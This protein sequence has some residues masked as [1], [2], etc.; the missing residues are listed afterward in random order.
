M[1]NVVIK[2]DLNCSGA[3]S[4]PAI[5]EISEVLTEMKK[6][7]RSGKV[8]SLHEYIVHNDDT[9]PYLDIDLNDQNPSDH[10]D[11]IT[12]IAVAIRKYYSISDDEFYIFDRSGFK[13]DKTYKLS[14]RVILRYVYYSH[15]HFIL[16]KDIPVLKTMIAG[17]DEA[18]YSDGRCMGLPYNCKMGDNRVLKLIGD[19][20][21]AEALEMEDFGTMKEFYDGY[22][23]FITSI[24]Y[25]NMKCID[26][27]GFKMYNP[28][29]YKITSEEDEKILQYI[30][31]YLPST[32]IIRYKEAQ[33]HTVV[34]L[35]KTYDECPLC[36]RIH[37]GNRNY[38]LVY[39]DKMV[40]KCHDEK[41]R[42]QELVVPTPEFLAVIARMNGFADVADADE[43]EPEEVVVEDVPIP[44]SVVDD[45][46]DDWSLA[47][48]FAKEYKILTVQH[49]MYHFDGYWKKKAGS[50]HKW[51]AVDFKDKMLSGCNGDQFRQVSKLASRSF[52]EKL[53]K[54][55]ADITESKDIFDENPNLLGFTNGVYDLLTDTF[56]EHKEDDY[57]SRIIP[58]D[59]KE[60]K[61]ADVSSLLEWFD[62]FMP[63]REEREFLLKLLSSTI[64]GKYLQNIVFFSGRGG[65]GK[66]CLVDLMKKTLGPDLM[67]IGSCTSLCSEK[68]GPNPEV[69]NM[70]MKRCV[71]FN[72][73]DQNKLLQASILKTISGSSTINARGLYQKECDTKLQATSIILC[74]EKPRMTE[75]SE[76]VAR[77]IIVVLFRA[78][79]KSRDEIADM[80]EG[81]LYM[82][83]VNT[84]YNSDEFRSKYK[85]AMLHLLLKYFRLF[86]ADGYKLDNV[87]Q[88]IRDAG[89]EYLADSDDFMNWFETKYS[90]SEEKEDFV[91]MKD[92]YQ[93]FQKSDLWENLPKKERRVQTK[94]KVCSS[95]ERN[96]NLR[97]FYR[98]RHTVYINGA[99]KEFNSVLL[100]WT[101]RTTEDL[102]EDE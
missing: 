63:I 4:Q 57:V 10:D 53:L 85:Y 94:K 16:K 84:Y 64:Y 23:Y 89:K 58:Y 28:A 5:Y 36:K 87:P 17:I 26:P 33:T 72:E 69:A 78:L 30:R 61:D 83:E 70:N 40:I 97:G 95:V 6:S 82:R 56:R 93:E 76:A 39:T 50:L 38:V 21:W 44:R 66:D 77:R 65:N 20:E 29:E 51:L 88:S 71:V 8:P 101:P 24:D 60:A 54:D 96:P 15:P 34:E 13:K 68:T 9:K 32:Y 47:Q 19:H 59:Y 3:K 31:K 35:A 45:R 11:F 2:K 75:I 62:S 43:Y 73:P 41:A 52:R 67:Y 25:K 27:V 49:E 18:V 81:T 14:A 99:Q 1:T 12:N 37:R 86:R 90:R 74:N 48:N 42:D 7:Y 22:D 79:F 80:P 92:V 102:V 91:Q 55:V 46:K 98:D 100:K